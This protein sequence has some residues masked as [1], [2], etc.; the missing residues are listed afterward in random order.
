[1]NHGSSGLLI[2]DAI[3]GLLL[4][5]GRKG[6]VR[7]PSPAIGMICVRGSSMRATGTWPTSPL[8]KSSRSCFTC[9][10]TINRDACPATAP[11]YRLRPFATSGYRSQRCSAGFETRLSCRAR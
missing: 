5:S 2:S 3:E 9:A 11:R 7:V 8:R 1:M 10:P 6:V 4:A